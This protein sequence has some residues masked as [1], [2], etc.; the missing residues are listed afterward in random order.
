MA[1]EEVPAARG[2]VVR[3]VEPDALRELLEHPP[4]ASVALVRDGRIDCIPVRA[5]CGG[6]SFAF[7]AVPSHGTGIDG[8]EVVLVIDEGPYWFQLRGLSVRGIAAAV[9]PP[10]AGGKALTWFAL[11]ASRVLA[12]DYGTIHE[13]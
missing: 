1:G 13:E 8:R 2:R 6:D 3:D 9:A 7:G 10:V 5:L 4:R 12:W 11:A